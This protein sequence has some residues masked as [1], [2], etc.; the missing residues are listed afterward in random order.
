MRN[1]ELNEE[2]FR[3]LLK[4]N[5]ATLDYN[6]YLKYADIEVYN[7]SVNIY[8]PNNFSKKQIEN[9]YYFVIKKMESIVNREIYIGVM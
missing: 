4:C 7:D 5:V 9:K 3:K 6:I 8:L 1:S 2:T